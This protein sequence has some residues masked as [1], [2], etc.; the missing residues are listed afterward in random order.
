MP[1]ET[2]AYKVRDDR[3]SVLQGTLEADSLALVVARLREMG[4][5]PLSIDRRSTTG[6]QSDVKIPWLHSRVK[7]EALAT[8]TRQFATMIESGLSLLRAVSVLAGQTESAAL[9]EVLRS[10]R[11]DIEQGSSLSNA[12]SRHPKAFP[13]IYVA[14]VRAGEIGGGL[15]EVLVRLADTLEKQVALQR[16]VKSAMA[17]PVGVLCLVG[18]ILVAMLLFIVPQFK[19]MYASLGGKLPLPTQ[20]LIKVSAAGFYLVPIGMVLLAASIYGLRRW[21]NTEAGRKTWD[22]FKLRVPLFGKLVHKTAL[23]RMGRTLS[24]L[25]RSG[26]PL[27]EALEVTKETCGNAVL[28]DALADVQEGV[29]RG[30]SIGH[31]LGGH[32]VVPAMVTQMVSVGE[33]SGAVDTML[34]KVAAFYESQVEAMVYTLTSL[35]EPFL[36]VILG[37]IVGSMVISLYLP[38]FKI[39]NTPGLNG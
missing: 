4:Y 3:G 5:T 7:S 19:N 32:A 39:L 6:L 21:I 37:G 12:L 26:V 28:A 14:M 29:R 8:F 16:K 35:L 20:I 11:L 31:R 1:T 9:A 18:V 24:A 10:V 27:L 36:I 23:A 34:E 2:F 33:E 17:Y 15:D 38:M 25:A 22:A 13:R 30:D